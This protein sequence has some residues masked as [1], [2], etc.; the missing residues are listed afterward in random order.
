MENWTGVRTSAIGFFS[1]IARENYHKLPVLESQK[2][3]INEEDV[4]SE[5]IDEEKSFKVMKLEEETDKC[6]V[7]AIVFAAIAVEAYIYDYASRNFSDAFVKT[8][9]DKL[10]PVSKWVIIPRLVTG[11]ELPRDHRWFELLNNL[12]Q[13]RNRIVHQKSSSPPGKIEDMIFYHKKLQQNSD[14]IYKTAREAIEL[15]DI[16]ANEIREIDPA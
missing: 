14:Q 2:R 3:E 15:L 1:N 10:D 13:Q 9:L 12:F 4:S 6:V 8:Y 11:K 7:L 5:T 16:L